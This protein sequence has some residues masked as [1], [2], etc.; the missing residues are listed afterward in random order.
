MKKKVLNVY[1]KDCLDGIGSACAVYEYGQQNDWVITYNPLSH[2]YDDKDFLLLLADSKYCDM[3][4]FTD[5]CMKYDDMFDLLESFKGEV[6]V[7]DHHKG[8]E[9]DLIKLKEKFKNFNYLFNEEKSGAV[10]TWEYYWKDIPT[11]IYHIED[12][13]LW[14]F[15]LPNTKEITSYLFEVIDDLEGEEL[16]KSF[17]NKLY[18]TDEA[19]KIGSILSNKRDKTINDIYYKFN[20]KYIIL[21]CGDLPNVKVFNQY[22]YKSELGNMFSKL[23][24]EPVGIFHIEGDKVGI[25][26]RSIDGQEYNA[27]QYAKHFGGNGH[28]N[29]SGCYVDLNVFLQNLNN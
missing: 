1:H 21:S 5:F 28:L 12:R 4:L 29:A 22:E 11:M 27:N 19:F 3:I 6:F 18:K 15:E 17:N 26:F 2:K 23:Y 9:E 8:V 14:K 25:S 20:E 24:N 16:I 10:L 7:I 13:D